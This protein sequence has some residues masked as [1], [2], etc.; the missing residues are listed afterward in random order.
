MNIVSL[1]PI[2][3][4]ES[5]IGIWGLVGGIPGETIVII[6]ISLAWHTWSLRIGPR[7]L[8]ETIAVAGINS[9]TGGIL[10]DPVTTC[11]KEKILN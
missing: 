7:L 1:E 9:A 10:I 2:I 5:A 6:R 3:V 8:P 11:F 4:L